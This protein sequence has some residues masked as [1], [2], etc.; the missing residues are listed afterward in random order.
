MVVKLL[1]NKSKKTLKKFIR[2]LFRIFLLFIIIAIIF[3]IV[4]LSGIFSV[5][6]ISIT[7][8]GENQDGTSLQISQIESLS[9][10]SV[11]QNLF[12]ISRGEIKNSILSNSYVDSVEVTKH[13]NGNVTI[14]VEERQIKYL[15]NY[16]G[17]YI[18]ID[19]KGNILELRSDS[20]EVPVLLGTST[21]FTSLAVGNSENVVTKLNEEDLE[22]LDTV[23]NIM[24]ISKS[25]DVDGLISRIDITDDKNYIIYLDSEAKTVY[26]GDCTNLNTRILYL[27]AIIKQESGIRGE[28]F[29]NVNL[30]SEYPYFRESV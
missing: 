23:N 26:L 22:K 18:Y 13:F 20:Q 9:K 6:S 16:A 25:N 19:N 17:S 24:E 30:D 2:I 1:K 3:S 8:D 27:K 28:I 15:I 21:D 11:G 12:E 5:K 4:F 29:L 7:I 14:N 10:L